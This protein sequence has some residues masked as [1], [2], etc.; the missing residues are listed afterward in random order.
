MAGDLA[1]I[2]QSQND[3]ASAITLSN[4][5]QLLIKKIP[6]PKMIDILQLANRGRP[7]PPMAF[8]ENLGRQEANP[9]DPDYKEAL[10]SFNVQR[11]KVLMDAFL[12]YG[13][14]LYV[15]PADVPSVDKPQE[16]MDGMGEIGISAPTSQRGIYLEWLKSVALAEEDDFTKVMD[17]VGRKSGVREQDVKNAAATFQPEPGR[18]TAGG[19]QASR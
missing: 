6:S 12:L 9:S 15:C 7:T 10:A 16:W 11:G 13:T 8:I 18:E 3:K 1:K 4:G 19:D 17:E 5:V 14:K 2:K